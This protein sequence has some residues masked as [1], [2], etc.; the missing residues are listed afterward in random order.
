MKTYVT[1]ILLGICIFSVPL[2][3]FAALDWHIRWNENEP[4]IAEVYIFNPEDTYQSFTLEIGDVAKTSLAD[5]YA[6]YLIVGQDVSLL[7]I[8]PSERRIFKIVVYRDIDSADTLT[9]ADAQASS[10]N[11]EKH[12]Q[13]LRILG[14][15]YGTSE[16]REYPFSTMAIKPVIR[17]EPHESRV[18]Y[19]NKRGYWITTLIDHE[20]IAEHLIRTG[21]QMGAQYNSIQQAI[22]YYT[23]GNIQL[24]GEAAKVWATA[25]P[26]LKAG[27][28]PTPYPD[29]DCIYFVT[30]VTT[31]LS[32]YASSRTITIGDILA[33]NSP[34]LS[35]VVAAEDISF[36]V[37]AN[38]QS[39]KR[40][41]RVYLMSQR[42]RPSEYSE[43]VKVIHHD[44]RIE[45][46]IRIGNAEQ[47]HACAIQ[48]VIFYINGE[49][50]SLTIGKGLWDRI[51]GGTQTPVPSVPTPGRQS[52]CLGNPTTQPVG[53]QT[54]SMT[55][56]NLIVLLGAVVPF[57]VLL[58]RKDR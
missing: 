15:K 30:V 54:A 6:P 53:G 5:P 12:R 16:S 52:L 45:Q 28:S 27:T 4:Q 1:V 50:P 17:E 34:A 26:E 21:D 46:A 19:R 25:F 38:T 2:T 29:G 7:Q 20:H 39:S 3:S 44:S 13:E 42:A 47:Y 57:S 9:T 8:A 48:D 58:R 31:N 36:N 41:L 55:F 10:L 49:V 43:Y 33:S 23:Q 18:I 14:E 35:P 51:G 22:F 24:T 56:K 32:Y 40:L 11:A 37:S